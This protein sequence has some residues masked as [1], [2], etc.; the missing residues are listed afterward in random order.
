VFDLMG[1][2]SCAFSSNSTLTESSVRQDSSNLLWRQ[3]SAK[4]AKETARPST[5]ADHYQHGCVPGL[6]GAG[7][8]SEGAA[9]ACN[10]HTNQLGMCSHLQGPAVTEKTLQVSS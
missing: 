1:L 5:D 10:P 4:E 7:Q 6:L 2:P 8:G 9:A 3:R